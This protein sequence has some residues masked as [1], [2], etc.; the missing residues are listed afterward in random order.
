[1][2]RFI[3]QNGRH[4]TQLHT[5]KLIYIKKCGWCCRCRSQ[6]IGQMP[7]VCASK[8][9][10]VLVLASAW[11]EDK[12]RATNKKK[13]QHSSIEKLTRMEIKR[14]SFLTFLVCSFHFSNVIVCTM[15]AA[16]RTFARQMQW[17]LQKTLLTY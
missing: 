9:L 16:D 15:F 10:L 7:M 11:H 12:Q 17:K 5:R 2:R 4:N 6:W 8:K 1:M 14:I 3:Q 13:N